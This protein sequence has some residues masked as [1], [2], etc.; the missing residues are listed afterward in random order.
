M[1]ARLVIRI[2]VSIPQMAT[3][4]AA[5]ALRSAHSIVDLIANGFDV[6]LANI[7]LMSTGGAVMFLPIKI[8]KES[9]FGLTLWTSCAT[10]DLY[11]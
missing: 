4:A 3:A 2:S 9:V 11:D 7:S 8:Y 5:A 10:Q 1:V 6:L